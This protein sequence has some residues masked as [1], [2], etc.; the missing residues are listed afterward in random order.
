MNVEI[1]FGSNIQVFEDKQNIVIGTTPDCDFVIDG[2]D[3]IINVK[4]VFSSKYNSYV[5]VNSDESSEVLF[6]NKTFKKVLVPR[7]FSIGHTALKESVLVVVNIESNKN[8]SADT[9][10]TVLKATAASSTATATTERA[11]T[12]VQNN[13]MINRDKKDIFNGNIENNR[14]AIVKEIGYKIQA[15]KN[16]I[17][18]LGKVSFVANAAILVLSIICSFGMTNF[19][20]HLPIDTSKGVLNLTTNYGFLIAISLIVFAVSFAMKQSVFSLIESSQNKR[21]GENNDIQ[22]LMVYAS[23]V[24]MLV[25]YAINLF[26]YKDIAFV[27]SIFVSLLFVGALA[28]VSAASGYFKY[29]LKTANYQLMN[30][31]YREDFETTLKGYRSLISQYINSLSDNKLD[32]IKDSLLNTQIKMSGEILIGML[33][34]PFLAYGVSNTLASCFPEA[35]GWIRISGLRFSPIFLVLATF[36]I[37]FAFFSFVR[38]FTI[39]KQIKAS[40]II[41]FD[42]FH[43]YASHGVNILGLDAIKGLHKEKNITMA[44]ACVIVAIEFTMNVSYFIQE[45]GGD[46]S[47][48]F[49]SSMAAFVPTALLIAETMM[50]SGTMHKINNYNEVFQTL[51]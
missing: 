14:I 48:M 41:K 28:I 8:V 32:S 19:I 16:Q 42:G 5:L 18:S 24:F 29:Q 13:R 10:N 44:I 23:C 49:I 39:G 9:D 3:E 25:I 27:A 50:L 6:N 12:Q 38:A 45:I 47:G 37:I 4:M 22:R 51:D 30:V 35:A 33:T 2:T 17:S 40:E 11:A 20:L 43:D 7:H 31:E 46:I 34:A 15:L 26:Y 21:Y 1:K 36:L